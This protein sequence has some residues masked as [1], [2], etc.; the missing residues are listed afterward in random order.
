MT[1]IKSV[2]MFDFSKTQNFIAAKLN[3]FTVLGIDSD[4]GL[5]YITR[6][7]S[8]IATAGVGLH[9]HVYSLPQFLS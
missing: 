7:A 6:I 1:K 5:I 3:W 8:M 2:K 4:V 9:V